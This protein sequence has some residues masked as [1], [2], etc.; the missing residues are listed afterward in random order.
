MVFMTSTVE[1]NKSDTRAP[2]STM[3]AHIH[4]KLKLST[5]TSWSYGQDTN[6]HFYETHWNME[7]T[8]ERDKI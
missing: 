4:Q 6:H 1:M 2:S 8:A 3:H 5:E 7:T